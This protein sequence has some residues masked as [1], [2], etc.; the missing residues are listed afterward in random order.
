MLRI[1]EVV[2]FLEKIREAEGNLEIQTITGFWV[3]DIPATGRKVII[4]VVGEG[5]SMED[6]INEKTS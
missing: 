1:D 4:P 6:L 2:T 3:R 5:K